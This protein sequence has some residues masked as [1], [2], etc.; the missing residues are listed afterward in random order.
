MLSPEYLPINVYYHNYIST[1]NS[2]FGIRREMYGVRVLL[3]H[4]ITDF[5]VGMHCVMGASRKTWSTTSDARYEIV[6]AHRAS[7]TTTLDRK[8]CLF[9]NLCLAVAVTLSK[10]ANSRASARRST[11]LVSEPQQVR[12]VQLT[13]RPATQASCSQNLRAQTVSF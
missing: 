9:P 12:E 6:D 3:N 7:L 1:P 8:R 5:H 13:L 11:I 10:T 4:Y 2:E